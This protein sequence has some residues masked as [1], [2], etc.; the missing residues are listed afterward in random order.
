MKLGRY[1]VMSALALGL[2]SSAAS[3]GTITFVTPAGATTG[4]GPV[5]ASATFITGANT[6]S[7]TL[8]NLQ[9]NIT[10]VA[11]AITDV[12]FTLNGGNESLASIT[13]SSAAR[14][15]VAGNGTVTSAGAGTGDWKLDLT[16][17][18]S[19][20]LHLCDI[21]GTPC[22]S[23]PEGA[24][25]GPPGAGGVYT[26]ANGSIAGNNAHNP[27]ISQSASWT[28]TVPGVTADTVVTAVTFSFGTT[29]GI[30]VPGIPPTRTPVPEPA[31]LTLL[32]TGFV[33][34]SSRL[35]RRAS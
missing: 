2:T 28:L 22:G 4:G 31:S 7:V 12:F 30:N 11:Q 21:G 8:T 1:F 5:N 25:L 19:G 10:D 20:E 15:T 18:S 16:N 13:N 29:A 9:A 23:G 3:A 35:R 17:A 14:I 26:A 6:V 27:F 34:L 24:I 32:G 33:Y